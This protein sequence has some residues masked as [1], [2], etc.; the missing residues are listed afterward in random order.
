MTSFHNT[1]SGVILAGGKSRRFGSNK[2]L[3]E[4]QGMPLVQFMF[5]QLRFLVENVSIN[6]NTP[7]E[8]RFLELPIYPDLIKDKGPIGGIHSALE[9][10]FSQLVFVTPC[11]LP[12]F[13][14]KLLPVLA[15]SIGDA[16]AICFTK[17][18]KIE[19]LPALFQRN[20]ISKLIQF[21]KLG[22]NSVHSFLDFC[23]T[24]YLPIESYSDIL[25]PAMLSNCNTRKDYEKLSKMANSY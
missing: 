7:E 24:S 13:S 23:D 5:N 14:F 10:S 22:D 1:I 2:A 9:N 3:I 20:S 17:A 18:H 15:G 16:D 6:S 12:H 11:D 21:M 8:F 19:P 25:N 4:V